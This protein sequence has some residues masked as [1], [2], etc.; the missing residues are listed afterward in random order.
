MQQGNIDNYLNVTGNNARPQ[1]PY[2]YTETQAMCCLAQAQ[3]SLK[4]SE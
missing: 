3:F 1:R 2:G 4:S